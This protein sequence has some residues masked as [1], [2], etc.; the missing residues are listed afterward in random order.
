VRRYRHTRSAPFNATALRALIEA[1]EPGLNNSTL[2]DSKNVEPTSNSS[3]QCYSTAPA[4]AL[5]LANVTV[6]FTMVL[7]GSAKWLVGKVGAGIVSS[8][9]DL[10]IQAHTFNNLLVESGHASLE[11]PRTSAVWKDFQEWQWL[12][13]TLNKVARGRNEEE[14]IHAFRLL[15]HQA[16]AV[17]QRR[18]EL[19]IEMA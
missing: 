9:D 19:Q 3:T 6:S 8:L 18:V 13:D 1:A 14:E 12:Q 7:A 17:G 4:A 16:M 10:L 15:Q 11:E 2:C 5:P